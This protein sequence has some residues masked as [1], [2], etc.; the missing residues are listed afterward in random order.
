MEMAQSSE[1]EIMRPRLCYLVKGERGYGFHL[2]GERNRGAQYVRKIEPGSPADLA[3]L[4]SGDRVVEVNGENVEGD[5]H[6][7]V[8][9]KIKANEHRTRLLVVDRGTD[10]LL[11]SRGLPCVEEL[12]VE[13]GCL[14]PR[15]SATSSPHVPM[16]PASASGQWDFVVK[17]REEVEPT[18]PLLNGQRSPIKS[19]SLVVKGSPANCCHD[20]P[21]SPAIG[22]NLSEL[23]VDLSGSDTS[24]LL[25][26]ETYSMAHKDLR[27]R[28][29]HIVRG[30]QGF[31]FN[32][33][34]DKMRMGQYIRCVDP[35]SPA[36]QSGLRPKDRLIEVNDMNIEHL[37]HSEVVAMIRRGG[38]QTSLL[39]VDPETDELF[40]RLGITPTN[41]HLEEDCVDGPVLESSGDDSAVSVDSPVTVV[42]VA[43]LHKSVTPSL[44]DENLAVAVPVI[45]VTLIDPPI[46]NGSPRHRSPDSTST[47]STLSEISTELSGSDTST[48]VK[49]EEDHQPFDPFRESGLQLSLT[50]AEA[51]QKA[52]AKRKKKKA[53]PMDWSKK[54]EL[55]SNF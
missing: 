39:V 6:H 48:K 28:E 15:S 40:K 14:S 44:E 24:A 35:G 20:S 9:Q 10:E 2:H 32:L 31:G 16:S 4:R 52:Y 23:S 42:D 36:E 11:R 49:E 13:M 27:P 26:Q 34:S 12:A 33:H 43:I 5:P 1:K 55:F 18:S 8:V 21:P 25:A 22:T 51:K 46:S 45:N 38:D 29:C 37:R 54:Q 30:E 53:P 47:R 41:K 3:G 19:P 7:L 50:A 17:A